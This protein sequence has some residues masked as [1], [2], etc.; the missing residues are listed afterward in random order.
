MSLGFERNFDECFIDHLL[1]CNRNLT[2]KFQ[3]ILMVLIR[4]PE[5]C[6]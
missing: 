5:V 6:N 1:D 2:V 3:L 4:F